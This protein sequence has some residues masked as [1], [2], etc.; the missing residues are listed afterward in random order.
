M[1]GTANQE[2]ML[3]WEGRMMCVVAKR[4]GSLVGYLLFHAKHLCFLIGGGRASCVF[5]LAHGSYPLADQILPTRRRT[6]IHHLKRPRWEELPVFGVA[7]HRALNHA[8]LERIEEITETG[9]FLRSGGSPPR[10]DYSGVN[11]NS[12]E[13]EQ[14]TLISLS[15]VLISAWGSPEK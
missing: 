14:P 1:A 6:E 11:S 13:A 15:S 4:L 9:V 5:A 12:E 8:G 7:C 3:A 2:P 10:V